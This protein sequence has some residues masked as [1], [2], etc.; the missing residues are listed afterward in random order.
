M[1]DQ[2]R[3]SAIYQSKF[4]ESVINDMSPQISGDRMVDLFRFRNKSE[5]G[6]TQPLAFFLCDVPH[7][8]GLLA[9]V[10]AKAAKKPG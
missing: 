4:V 10:N 2:H 7:L 1:G 9:I 3:V 5:M 8:A 6:Q